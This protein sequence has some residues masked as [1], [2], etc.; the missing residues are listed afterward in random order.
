MI[1]F[2]LKKGRKSNKISETPLHLMLLPA[3]IILFVYDYLPMA[4]LVIAFQKFVPAKGLFGKQKWV[5]LDN[6]TYFFNMPEFERVLVNTLTIAVLKIIVGLVVPVI[7]ALLLNE[8]GNKFVK[9]SIQTMIYL[10]H[11]LSWVILGGILINILSPQSGIVNQLLGMVGVKPI[12]F[13]GDNKWFRFTLIV[14][15]EW[16]EFGWG[17]IIYL[18]ALTGIDQN[19]YEAAHI[20]GANRIQQTRYI[21][22]PG[23]S[24]IIIM[25]LVMSLGKILNAGFDQVF[26]L[27]SPV[28]Y[29]SGDIIDTMVYRVGLIQA[30]FGLSTAIGMFKSVISLILISI[31]YYLAYK[32]TNYRVF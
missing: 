17:T 16:K 20:D 7:V 32:T 14:T 12:F 11:F 30:Q 28:V 6:F 23:I 22:I 13:L 26:N 5:G 21:T 3:V 15:H 8:L 1:G 27:Y 31:S 10:P 18:A 2:N 24:H 4:G 29:E 19:L 25:M 9:R